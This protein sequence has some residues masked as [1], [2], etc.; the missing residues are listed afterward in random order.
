MSTYEEEH[1]ERA[2][3]VLIF[4]TGGHE[5]LNLHVQEALYRLGYSWNSDGE[6]YRYLNA[7]QITAR[8][9][10]SLGWSEHKRKPFKGSIVIS[11]KKTKRLLG[12][13]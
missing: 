6:H 5:E 13:K 10:Y 12:I 9:N 4:E 8:K 7:I 11:L 3:N 1:P 2:N